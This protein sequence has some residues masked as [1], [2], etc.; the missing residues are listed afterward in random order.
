[1]LMRP[2][3]VAVAS[4]VAFAPVLASAAPVR[5]WHSYRGDEQR[6]L[7]AFAATPHAVEVEL[8]AV[9][10]DAF[11]AKL[12]AAI[13]LGEGP[14]LFID[15]H[16]RLGDYA[17]QGLVAEVAF[18]TKVFAPAA[19]DGVTVDG[20]RFGI[21]LS[22]K[23][24]ALYVNRARVSE[25]PEFLEELSAKLRG[26]LEPG[27]VLLA[28]ESKSA[29]YHAPWL[30][31]FGGRLLDERDG[32]GFVG[33]PAVRSLELAK[34]WLERGDV[35]GNADGALVTQ[36]FRSGRAA[37]AI[38]G[39]WLAGD[40]HAEGLRYDVVPLPT[41]R[42]TGLPM[43]PLLTIEAVMA[44]PKGARRPEVLALAEELGSR[45]A[46]VLRMD[47]AHVVPARV[48]TGAASDPVV[49]GFAAAAARAVPMPSS[50]AMR[51]VWE[52]SEKAIRKVL[53]G[54]ADAPSALAEAAR[55]F[56][57]V[58]RPAPPPASRTPLLV[59]LGALLVAAAL[60]VVR[61]AKD[62]AFRSELRASVPVYRY[63]A[64]AVVA[65]GVL[66]FA[67]LVAG[68][69]ISLSAGRPGD[70]VYVGFAN[71]WS[72]LTARGGP[73]LATGSFYVV[74]AVTLLWTV[75]NVA[76][77]LGLGMTLGVLLSR[78]V[79]RLKAVYRVLLI[80]PWAV[81]SYVTALAWKGMFHRQFGAVTALLTK[82]RALGFE[83]APIDWFARFSTAFAANLATNVW[84]GFPFMMVVTLAAMTSVPRDVLEAAEVDGA[85][86]WQR[87]TKIVVPIVSPTMIPA[88][89]LGAV[90][91]FNMF[92][93]VFLVSG[94]EPDGQTDIL[95]SE[96]YRWAFTR[97]AQYGYAAAYSVLIFVLLFG[98]TKLPELLRRK[99]VT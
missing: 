28:Y 44:S 81:P 52:P 73:L 19:V 97:Q 2:L 69:F 42:E 74:L 66:V 30:S 67:P 6:A 92:N 50:V 40:L 13:P 35:P 21:P 87:F 90:W 63:V 65:L 62:A 12:S 93:V 14:D 43:R 47:T 22:Q 41:L 83:V 27:A 94:G 91:T 54:T 76:L 77:H 25:A 4:V 64:H 79:L 10:S 29:Y 26:A 46:A 18:D 24:V 16:E 82:A 68:A 37:Y 55:R 38:S 78:P 20:R 96:A 34:T 72:I 59:V 51:A 36:L 31:A 39:P 84:L 70:S 75:A 88:V 98:A 3:A 7:E 32:Y 5:V 45:E 17:R 57:D 99:V 71:F 23:C 86:R 11:A 61:R 48:D 15:A 8:L 89:S 33:A 95:V 85:T 53:N 58:R 80:L 1:M 60:A 9:P 49:R 56:D